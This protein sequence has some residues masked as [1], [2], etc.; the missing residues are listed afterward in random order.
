MTNIGT[1]NL[2][3]S[4]FKILKYRIFVLYSTLKADW[5]IYKITI[6]I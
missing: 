6:K 5:T 4:F 1:Y 2:I 3:A